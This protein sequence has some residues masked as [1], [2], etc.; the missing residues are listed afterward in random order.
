MV[1]G[2]VDHM[3]HQLFFFYRYDLVTTGREILAQIA[4]PASANFTAATGAAKITAAAV[5]A[6]GE[7][8][9]QVLADVDTLVN[10]DTAFQ[11]G[12]WLAMAR[13]LGSNGTGTGT[14]TD[15]IPHGNYLQMS[16]PDFYGV[17]FQRD[18][19]YS[20]NLPITPPKT[21]AG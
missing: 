7:Y 5:V 16:Y 1:P 3:M 13:S 15:C 21:G 19:Y 4:G 18:Q 12:P 2:F 8:Y 14:D 9:Y 17:Q 20:L 10:T 6:T 11:L